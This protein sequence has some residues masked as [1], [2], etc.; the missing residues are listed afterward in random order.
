MDNL[1]NELIR[2]VLFPVFDVPNEMFRDISDTSPFSRPSHISPSSILGV[3][4][5]WMDVGAPLL[6]R[7]VVLR[8]TAQACALMHT[9]CKH[10]ELGVHIKKL[11]I[12]GGYGPAMR[13][14]IYAAPTVTDLCISLDIRSS[15]DVNGL[16]SSLASINPCCVVV[17]AP[18]GSRT[19]APL[20]ALI[21]IL[22]ACLGSWTN[23]VSQDQLFSKCY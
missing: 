22:S 2:E 14:I 5:R 17:L 19:N 13:V 3:C 1:P 6:Y 20:E 21:T 4:K 12:E 8:S 23:M 11:R 10:K 9:L 16:C 15:D 18:I 7:V